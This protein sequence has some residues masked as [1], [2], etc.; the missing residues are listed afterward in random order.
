MFVGIISLL[1]RKKTSKQK[2][3]IAIGTNYALLYNILFM[4]ELEIEIL[5]KIELKPYLWWR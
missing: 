2:R 1:L 4:A 5:S 3:G